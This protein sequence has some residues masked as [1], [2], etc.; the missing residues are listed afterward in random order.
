MEVFTVGGIAL[1][2]NIY[3]RSLWSHD[4]DDNIAPLLMFAV[5]GT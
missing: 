1:G 3:I 5:V 2:S 4:N